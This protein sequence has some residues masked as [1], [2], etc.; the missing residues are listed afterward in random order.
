MESVLF[1]TWVVFNV[2]FACY[3]LLKFVRL[4]LR[5]EEF[6]ISKVFVYGEFGFI[7][8]LNTD[9]WIFVIGNIIMAAIGINNFLFY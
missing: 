9:T 1:S 7:P 6:E 3:F 5:E 2:L 8:C 4:V